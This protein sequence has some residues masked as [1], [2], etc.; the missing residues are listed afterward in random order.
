MES[1]LRLL[2]LEDIPDDAAYIVQILQQANFRVETQVVATRETFMSALRTFHPDVIISDHQLPQF[3]S[4][5]ALQVARA[6]FP[7]IPFILVTGACTDEFAASIIK[8]GADDYLLKGNL[9]RLPMAIRQAINK[10]ETEESLRRSEAN[11]RT[12]F[13]HT[14]TGYILVDDNF[15]LVSFNHC[16]ASFVTREIRRQL[17]AGQN[18][19]SYVAVEDQQAVSVIRDVLRDGHNAEYE[20]KVPGSK[21]NAWFHVRLHPVLIKDE[22]VQQLI[23]AIDDITARKSTAD[24]LVKAEL[25]FRGILENSFEAVV[26]IND[27]AE[28]IYMSHAAE[29]ISR[30]TLGNLTNVSGFSFIHPEE[31]AYSQELFKEVMANPG[32]S[33][34]F[35]TRLLVGNTD[36]HIEGFVTNLLHE[37]NVGAIV[38]NYHDVSARVQAQRNLE[39]TLKRFEQA[40][41]IA[42]LGHWEIDLTAKS[43]VWSDETFRILGMRPGDARP[44]TTQMVSHIHPDDWKKVKAIARKG[45]ET[46]QPFS[47][48]HRVVQNSGTMRTLF[49]VGQYEKDKEGKTLGIYG[50]SLDVTDITEKEKKL[51]QAKN[52]LETFIYKAYHDLRS[53]IVSVLGAV[54]AA[55]R[56]ITEKISR[57]YFDLIGQV[58]QKQN[59][60]LLTLMKVMSIR[61]REVSMKGFDVEN[62]LLD[63][64]DAM[65]NVEGFGEVTF[66]IENNLSSWFPNDRDLLFDILFHLSENAI[67]Y[68]NKRAEKSR[69]T[70]RLANDDDGNAIIEVEDNGVGIPND[71]KSSVFNMFY[72]GSLLSKGSGLGL[73]LVKNAVEKLGGTAELKSS[74]NSGTTFRIYLPNNTYAYQKS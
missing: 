60:M 59:R 1:K 52:E 61:E 64:L 70:I 13:E 31:F 28:L 55:S 73:Y 47:F 4:V 69:V 22:K 11:L 49:S 42:H 71:V 21:T 45:Q 34:A 63:L 14:D 10:K 16:A 9:K 8:E 50:V 29:R 26:L 3:S 37:E 68:R 51:E 39:R 35:Q 66:H 48:Y 20:L 65:R 25:R 15:D 17:K 58:A 57:D 19:F 44:S 5:E 18:L 40:Q 12:I 36:V 74:E 7:Y 53:P 38:V 62:L 67:Q 32:K 72:R 6:R 2:L 27:K 30:F 54:N 43:S 41:E 56:E 23:I 46:N 24:K 33:I